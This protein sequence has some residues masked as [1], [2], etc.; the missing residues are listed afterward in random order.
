MHFDPGKMG[1]KMVAF[2]G[3]PSV[4]VEGV[5]TLPAVLVPQ[6]DRFII[7]GRHDQAAVRGK[8]VNR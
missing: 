4:L 6:L 1:T 2:R 7:T 3:S 8:P 5:D